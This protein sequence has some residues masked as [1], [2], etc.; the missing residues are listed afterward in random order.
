MHKKKILKKEKKI[1]EIIKKKKKKIRNPK[2]E[3]NY[4]IFFMKFIISV[5]G[6]LL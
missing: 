4:F 1:I 5:V 3:Y 6:F 2:L